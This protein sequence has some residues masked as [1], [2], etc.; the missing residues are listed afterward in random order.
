MAGGF[1]S[2]MD[3]F[4]QAAGALTRL[5]AG[6][7]LAA[8]ASV[9][10]ASAYLIREAMANFEGAHSKGQPHVG[11]NKPNVVTGNLRR[12]I[13][14]DSI[15]TLRPGYYARDVG[16]TALYA[17][18]VELGREGHSAA[19]PYFAPAVIQLRQYMPSLVTE[20]WHKYVHP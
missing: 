17:R 13:L 5:S 9:N 4:A 20:N 19:Y 15:E 14:A 16:P 11:G 8:R 2:T 3:G 12:S 1:T 6:S 10:D 7:E 18:A